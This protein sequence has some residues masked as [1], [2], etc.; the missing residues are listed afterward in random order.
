ML[1]PE[2]AD[3]ALV[4]SPT[5]L[6]ILSA[7]QCWDFK[8]PPCLSGSYEGSENPAST[9]HVVQHRVLQVHTCATSRQLV[10]L[11]FVILL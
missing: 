2:F 8:W 11:Y 7:F 9:P 5:F 4:A 6:G 1:H 3:L 10:S